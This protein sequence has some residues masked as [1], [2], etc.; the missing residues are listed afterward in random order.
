M[1]GRQISEW[2]QRRA[3]ANLPC[4]F[5]A[6]L[7]ATLVLI[8]LCSGCSHQEL[9][10]NSCV[11]HPASSFAGAVSASGDITVARNGSPCEMALV[12]DS[13]TGA[14]FVSDPQLITRPA[15]GSASV[16]MS[17]GAAVM[18]Y[19]P[20]R[21]YVGTDRFVVSFGP[22]YTLSVAVAVVP[23]PHNE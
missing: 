10:R 17:G 1:N 9:T 15:H 18:V 8:L 20:D 3:I 11:V 12:L 4:G 19:T 13:R 16:R 2:Q 5:A 6:R 7:G 14:G 22:S 21:D 23:P